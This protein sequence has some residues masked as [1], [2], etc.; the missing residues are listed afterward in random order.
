M[1]K[2]S[3]FVRVTVINAGVLLPS[4]SGRGLLHQPR[5]IHKV[6]AIQGNKQERFI[7]TPEM[8]TNNGGLSFVSKMNFSARDSMLLSNLLKSFVF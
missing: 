4:R 2:P 6:P 3:T 1:K 7:K 8:C 5:F